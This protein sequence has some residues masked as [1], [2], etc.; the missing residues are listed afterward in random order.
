M[1]LG[2]AL[3]NYFSVGA[4]TQA[5]LRSPL[6]VATTYYVSPS[7]SDSNPGTS[8]A[9][10]RTISKAASM[11][12]A[13]GTV[14]VYAGIYYEQVTVASSG[15]ASAP[16]TIRAAAGQQVIVDGG[17]ARDRGFMLNG[18]Y[19]VVD[20][21]EVRQALQIC[22]DMLGTDITVRNFTIHNC[23][24]AGLRVKN[25]NAI[26]ESSAFYYN[27]LSNQGGVLGSGWAA[28]LRVFLGGENVTI[29]NNTVYYN[30]GEGI[31]V[32]QGKNVN[33]LNNTVHDNFSQNIYINNSMDVDVESN[34]VYSTNPT[35][36]RSGQPANGIALAEENFDASWGAQLA[37]IR[38]VNN[39]VAYCR[40]GIG[41][42]YAEVAGGL[43]SSTIA[44]NTIW[45]STDMGLVVINQP[46]KTRN[47]VIA[48][49]IVQ[50]PSG[51]LADIQVTSG[52]SLHHNFWVTPISVLNNASGMGDRTGDAMLSSAPNTAT[53]TSFRLSY[54]S[55]ARGSGSALDVA[56]DF[57]ANDRSQPPDMGAIEYRGPGVASLTSPSANIGNN[58]KPTYKWNDVAG[59]TWYYLWVN[60]PSAPVIQK[61]YQSAD[62]CGGGTCSVTPD[63]TLAGGNHAWWIQTWNAKGLGPWSSRMDFT[64]NILPAPTAATLVSPSASIGSN[65][66]PTYKWNEVASS[67]WYYLWINGPSG[68]ILQKWYQSA[69]VCSAGVCSATPDLTLTGGNY[70]WWIQTWNT[71]GYG[72]WSSAMNFSTDVLTAPRAATLVSPSGSLGSN[73]KPTYTWNE[74]ANSTWYYLW[75]NGPS[76]VIIQKWYRTADVCSGGGTC[77]ITPDVT[78]TGGSYTWWIQTWNATGYGPWSSGMAFSTQ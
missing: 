12:T 37:R 46:T 1:A 2:I 50:Q 65:Y 61:W 23:Q 26:V 49:N 10:F 78:L 16:I 28:T 60:G 58:Y 66:K 7:G 45:G 20:G 34:F 35:F 4:K 11:V 72:P 73:S 14:Q 38:V 29:R 47:S 24:R 64:T 17:M 15:T 25:K 75:V 39:I 56:T 70:T 31:A 74:V 54:Y 33:V 52:I 36:Y 8:S 27:S 43:D 57:E 53:P 55:P 59:S 42:T 77:S 32:G 13:G 68:V 40:R 18:S 48:N 3:G 41:Y 30:W 22:V 63:V 69:N 62:V 51:R 19:L 67:T 9:P 44:F 6:A 71:T 76:G 21:F 5:E